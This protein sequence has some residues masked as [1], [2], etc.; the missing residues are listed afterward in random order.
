MS[1]I[2]KLSPDPVIVFKSPSPRDIY[3]YSPGI[4]VAE[5]G[6]LVCTFDLGGPGAERLP[7]SVRSCDGWSLGKIYTSD[8]GGIAWT[9][10]A[11]FPFLH[12][13]PFTAGGAIYI[14]GHAGDIHIMRSTD[15]GESWSEPHKLTH[16]ENWMSACC[17]VL[18]DKGYVY[19]AMERMSS[20]GWQN[21]EPVLLRARE[22]D[23]L[24]D[25]ASWTFSDTIRAA[26]TIDMDKTAYT[27][28]PFYCINQNRGAQVIPGRLNAG[29]PGWLE[30]N[31]TRIYDPSH[32]WHDPTGHTYHLFARFH[33]GGTNF[34]AIFKA[35][36]RDDGGI[37]MGFEKNPSGRDVVF[38]PMPGGHMK[39]Y[40][41]YDEVTKFY[42]LLSTQSTDSMIKPE[43]MPADR[44]NLPN[45]ERQRLVL[46]FSKN[47]V[48]WCFAGLVDA[49]DTQRQAR[50]Y[51]SMTAAGDDLLVVSR[52]GDADAHDAHNTDIVTFHRIHDFRRLIY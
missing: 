37:S 49:G 45:N 31:V 32:I 6:R 4:L 18:H 40:I 10:R 39:F 12:A 3:A 34:C 23:D 19:L 43:L 27:P 9:H 47:L 5:G 11:D 17:N 28:I 20:P 15:N 8:D 36:E 38:L 51:A 41:L 24:L 46:H 33:F 29:A 30:T 2:N 14:I 48:D 1:G 44:F 16:G 26:D 35:A 42:W 22:G 13:R 7:G 50:H 21:M 52:S 25:V